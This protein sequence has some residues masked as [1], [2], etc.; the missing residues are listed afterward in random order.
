MCSGVSQTC[1]RCGVS[2]GWGGGM[3]DHSF[4]EKGQDTLSPEKRFVQGPK[5]GALLLKTKMKHQILLSGVT[6]N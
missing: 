5:F 4:W 1:G 6:C 3:S 2:A